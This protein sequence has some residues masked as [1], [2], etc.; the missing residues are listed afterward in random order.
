MAVIPLNG[1][2]VIKV[3]D[4]HLCLIH[5]VMKHD[6]LL[7]ENN[8]CDFGNSVQ[9]IDQIPFVLYGKL[10]GHNHGF[11]H[12]GCKLLVDNGT[13]NIEIS[14]VFR[15]SRFLFHDSPHEPQIVADDHGNITLSCMSQ[16]CLSAP[17]SQQQCFVKTRR[18]TVCKLNIQRLVVLPTIDPVARFHHIK[19]ELNMWIHAL[20][21]LSNP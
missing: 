1:G 9:F 16:Y 4:P 12:L 10:I 18:L 7:K 3:A 19:I 8:G 21:L 15:F 20:A 11:H 2:M 17:Q 13:Q 5:I 14:D 6:D